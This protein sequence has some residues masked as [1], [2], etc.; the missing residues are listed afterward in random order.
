MVS[1]EIKRITWNTMK[2]E[3]HI[4]DS[5]LTIALSPLRKSYLKDNRMREGREMNPIRERSTFTFAYQFM[6]LK[7]YAED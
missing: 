1:K 7:E 4:V 2:S 6:I 3:R 5:W